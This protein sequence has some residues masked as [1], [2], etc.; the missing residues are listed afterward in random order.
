MSAGSGTF[1][2]R[3]KPDSCNTLQPPQLYP[4]HGVGNFGNVYVIPAHP[5]QDKMVEN[6]TR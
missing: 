3:E 4:I 2:Y 6:V 1:A 5:N